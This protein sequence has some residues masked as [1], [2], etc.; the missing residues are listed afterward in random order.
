MALGSVAK[1]PVQPIETAVSYK[2]QA[3]EALKSALIDIDIYGTPGDLRLDERQLAQDL[4]VSRTPI[5]EALALLEQEGFVRTLP[6]RGIFVVRKTKR[7]ILEMIVVWA[8]LEGMAARLITLHASDAEI[9]TLRHMFAPFAATRPAAMLDEYSNQN[10]RFHQRLIELS[11]NVVL[12]KTAE[13]LFLHMRAI[14]QR[15]IGEN[16]R[17][18]R[19]IVDHMNIIRALEAR[20][21]DAAERLARQHTL[22]LAAHVEKNVDYLE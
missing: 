16:D 13:N 2:S 3:Y 17:A 19:S 5:R 1:L 14:R 12:L 6:R 4:G 20:D 8:A 9:A 10:I 15:T 22:D 7:E 18:T 11:H 21:T